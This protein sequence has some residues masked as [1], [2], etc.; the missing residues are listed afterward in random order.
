MTD[1]FPALAEREDMYELVVADAELAA[2]GMGQGYICC[3]TTGEYLQ[4]KMGAEI[5]E[6]IWP[7]LQRQ[8]DRW[9]TPRVVVGRGPP[10]RKA[11]FAPL[12]T[13]NR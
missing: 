10:T 1:E 12:R 9:P 11:L 13:C 6:A 8:P 7:P 5:F 4:K 2:G 3:S